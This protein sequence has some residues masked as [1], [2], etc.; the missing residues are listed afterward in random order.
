MEQP[1]K[2][3]GSEDIQ[4][5]LRKAEFEGRTADF[6]YKLLPEFSFSN[7]EIGVSINF[8]GS[9][10]QGAAYFDKC[11][12]KGDVNLEDVLI[13]TSLYIS[14]SEFKENFTAR[15]IRVREVVN[16]VAS[17]FKKNV[18]FDG[19][20]IKGYLGLNKTKVEENLSIKKVSIIDIKTKTG[21]IRGDFFLKEAHIKGSVFLE[22]ITAEGLANL[23]NSFI[24]GNLSFTNSQIKDN[25]LLTGTIVE[26]DVITQGLQSK[27]LIAH[28]KE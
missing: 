2:R 12:F 18:I 4:K 3:I 27:N 21:T 22:E 1:L 26:G 9:T 6:T 20:S 15:K 24:E 28:M 25:V 23:E 13:Y 7:Q 8:K 10:I 14:N 19:A 16:L 17:D 5:E 11:L